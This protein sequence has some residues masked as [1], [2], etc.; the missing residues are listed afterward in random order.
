MLCSAM[1][2]GFKQ[3]VS[4]HLINITTGTNYYQIGD[5]LT[6]KFFAVH[7]FRTTQ[8]YQYKPETTTVTNQIKYH[9]HVKVPLMA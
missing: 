5:L 7:I 1:C 3:V 9:G 4:M 2:C 8:I 6:Y